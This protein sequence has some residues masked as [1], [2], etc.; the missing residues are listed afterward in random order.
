MKKTLFSFVLTFTLFMF[1]PGY[2]QDVMAKFQEAEKAYAASRLDDARFALQEAI[3]GINQEIGKETLKTLPKILGGLPADEKQDN[4]SGAAGFAG[5]SITRVYRNETKSARVEILGDSP[6]L[7]NLNAILALPA[8][9]GGSDPN[10]KRV[11]VGGYKGLLQK[12]QDEV[13]SYNLQVP[14]NQILLTLHVTGIPDEN[15]VMNMAN[16]LPL[17]QI[18]KISQ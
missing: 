13:I 8:I 4:V 10:Q 18:V 11:K 16:A 6:L 7:A 14:I 5:V 17:D 15:A 3:N 9:M 1:L 2:A 12:E